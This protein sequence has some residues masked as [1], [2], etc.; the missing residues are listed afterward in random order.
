M[1]IPFF[2]DPRFWLAFIIWTALV[3]LGAYA[4]GHSDATATAKVAEAGR[5]K[6][7]LAVLAAEND[8][9]LAKE[10]QLRADDR[11]AL[12]KFQLENSHAKAET[13][14]LISDLRRDVVRLR[15]PIRPSRQAEPAPGGPAPDG[16][17]AQGQAELT[18][19][20][21]EFVVG[22]LA[23]GDEG[24]RKHAEVVDRYERLRL[25]CTKTD[26]LP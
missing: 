16:V 18:A 22:L 2:L 26:Q 1:K 3:T 10:R 24:I 20:A 6:I 25:A 13:D 4:F 19:D 14:R 5:T 7:A 11:A 17:G 23:R 9:E 12:D 15:V 8:K 21:S